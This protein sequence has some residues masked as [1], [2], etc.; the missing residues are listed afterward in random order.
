MRNFRAKE[1]LLDDEKLCLFGDKIL[2]VLD[3]IFPS[4]FTPRA[5][6]TNSRS[7]TTRNGIELLISRILAYDMVFCADQSVEDKQVSANGTVRDKDIR[8]IKR[9]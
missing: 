5:P 4:M 2:E 9:I 8:G 7:K 6:K 3:V 1:G